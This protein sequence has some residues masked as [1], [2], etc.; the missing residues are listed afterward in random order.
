MAV[1]SIGGSS[2][3]PAL[4]MRLQESREASGPEKT[5]THEETASAAA[6]ATYH[7]VSGA[8]PSSGAKGIDIMA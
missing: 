6:P 8:S 7:A 1:N 4:W 2:A 5:E 3:S